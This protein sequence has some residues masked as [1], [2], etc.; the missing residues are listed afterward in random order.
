MNSEKIKVEKFFKR[1]WDKSVSKAVSWFLIGIF[2]FIIMI[3]CMMPAQ[4]LFVE[5]EDSPWLMPGVLTMLSFMMVY[6][7]EMPYNQYTDNQKSRFMSEI[8]RY[9]PIDKKEIWKNKMLNF[10]IIGF[11]GLG[12][13]HFR[14]LKEVMKVEKDINLVGICDV[15]ESAFTSQVKMNIGTENS[16]LDV[17]KYKFYKDAEEMFDKEQLDFV[18][19]ALPTYLHAPIAIMAMERGIHVFSEK[20]MAVNVEQAQAMLDAAKKNKGKSLFLVTPS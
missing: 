2:L 13:V 3:L 1:L 9:H 19:T 11:G 15:E 10:A 20:P 14:N 4:G 7:R 16:N 18:I 6:F 12:K 8:L 17:T 5:T